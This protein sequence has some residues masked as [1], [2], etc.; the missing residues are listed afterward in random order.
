[1]FDLID[2]GILDGMTSEI[3]LGLGD[4]EN[5]Y[6]W[7]PPL[8]PLEIRI[9]SWDIIAFGRE[10]IQTEIISKLKAYEDEIKNKGLHEYPSAICDHARL[11]FEK[12]VHHKTYKDLENEYPQAGREGIKRAVWNF[13]RFLNIKL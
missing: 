10:P 1:M 11:W 9:S 7:S 12:H 5:F 3:E 4:L 8:P 6:P 13:R 2:C